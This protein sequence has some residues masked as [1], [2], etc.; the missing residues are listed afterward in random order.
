MRLNDTEV[1][2]ILEAVERHMPEK[3]GELRLYGSRVDD[4]KKGGDIDL[5]LIMPN[6]HLKQIL[7]ENKHVIL[8]QIKN[9]I[10]ER[11]IDLLICQKE[12]VQQDPFVGLIYPKSIILK[13]W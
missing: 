10:G 9:S 4:N 11:K 2:G 5:L 1:L 6:L 8:G 3:K 12:D 7:V 13:V